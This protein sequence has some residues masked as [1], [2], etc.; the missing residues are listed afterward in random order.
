[1]TTIPADRA[2]LLALARS[3]LETE[4][5]AVLGFAERLGETFLRALDLL[6]ACHGRV[7][8]TGMGKSGIIARKI[9]STL[10]STGTSAYFL[11]PAEALHGD[12]GVV[13]RDDLV[14]ALSHSGETPR[15]SPATGNA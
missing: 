14:V 8:V 15:A 12:L 7:I 3:V 1:M 10:S 5:H 9:A 13:Q 2:S 6:S 4:A 11:H